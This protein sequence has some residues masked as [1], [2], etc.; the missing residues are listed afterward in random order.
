MNLT[1]DIEIFPETI[2]GESG[3]SAYVRGEPQFFFAE[4]EEVAFLLALQCKYLGP[5][6]QFAK[7]ACR[8]LGNKSAWAE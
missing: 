1:P 2:G 3:F 7:F 8:M 4:T 5:N 6:S